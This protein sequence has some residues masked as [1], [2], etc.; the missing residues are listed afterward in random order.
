MDSSSFAGG[1]VLDWNKF[2]YILSSLPD[3]PNKPIQMPT[4]ACTFPLFSSQ[5]VN[6]KMKIEFCFVQLQDSISLR[7]TWDW[8]PQHHENGTNFQ[9]IITFF[10]GMQVI[11]SF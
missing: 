6:V 2:I 4:S 8:M 1:N 10:G 3:F 7:C 11:T 9:Q 5:F